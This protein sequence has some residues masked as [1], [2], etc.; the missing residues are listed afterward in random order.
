[1]NH[2]PF[3]NFFLNEH[4]THLSIGTAV[5]MGYIAPCFEPGMVVINGEKMSTRAAVEAGII[6]DM[7]ADYVAA[8]PLTAEAPLA[9]DMLLPSGQ[10]E[11]SSNNAAA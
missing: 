11:V 7:A 4:G 10:R 8:L 5:A 6:D 3:H 2:T 1:M 9:F